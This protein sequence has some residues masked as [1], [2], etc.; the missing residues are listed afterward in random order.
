MSKDC[1]FFCRGCHTT[2]SSG[3]LVTAVKRN[4]KW[5]D[6]L[7]RHVVALHST[8]NGKHTVSGTNV[9]RAGVA[10]PSHIRTLAML[11]YCLQ[12]TEEQDWSS[13]Q[14]HYIHMKYRK[15]GQLVP[16]LKKRY[17]GSAVISGLL[18]FWMKENNVKLLLYA[19]TALRL[20]CTSCYIILAQIAVRRQ[21]RVIT[22][23]ET[24]NILSFISF[25]LP[26]FLF[27]NKWYM[28]LIPSGWD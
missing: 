23:F 7:G 12:K 28:S 16:K 21:N 2:G 14:K 8:R 13:L 20:L 26:H 1:K 18:P 5:K 4:A 25:R 6:S 27:Q 24:T 15:S 11:F 17:T 3:S 19:W 22:L 9:R 10:L